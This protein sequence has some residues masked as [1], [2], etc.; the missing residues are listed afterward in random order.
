MGDVLSRI[1]K[2]LDDLTWI[3]GIDSV[4]LFKEVA[5]MRAQL[6]NLEKLHRRPRILVAERNPLRFLSVLLSALTEEVDLFLGNPGWGRSE[7]REA[8]RIASPDLLVTSGW[9]E[10]IVPVEWDEEQSPDVSGL[11]LMV[12]TGGSSG[13]VKFAMHSL[14]N[15]G[16]AVDG[17]C[18]HFSIKEIHSY[19]VLPLYHVSG[20]MQLFRA[21][22]T[23]GTVTLDSFENLEKGIFPAIRESSGFISLVPTQLNRLLI[24]DGGADWLRQFKAVFLGGGPAWPEL[25]KKG[26][27]AG[28]PLS[29]TYGM[30][31]SAA[32]VATLKP[33]AFLSGEND[34][35]R[36]LPHVEIFIEEEDPKT[37]VGSIW[38]K[39]DALFLGYHPELRKNRIL[40]QTDDL[41]FLNEKGSLTVVGRT[42]ELINSGGEKVYPGEVEKVIRRFLDVSAI[43]V[44]GIP[45]EIWG[46]IVCAV[47]QTDGGEDISE[48]K[49]RK[50]L[51][52]ELSSF[53]IPK[54]W[55]RYPQI[56]ENLPGKIDREAVRSWLNGNQEKT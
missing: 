40:W 19:C 13:K 10:G 22:L 30:T 4:A 47:Y 11:L 28:L 24:V 55:I 50:L 48:S 17:L 42:D 21:L 6:A 33:E 49:M 45:D 46:E 54:K 35:G 8:M 5:Q 23:N 31:E 1:E 44:L 36:A 43:V 7:Q 27:D 9:N 32:Q 37:E 34:A 16:V 12:P 29:L 3:K 56:L 25:L 41:G 39:S 26:R 38:L 2:G 51:K 52:D 53:K 15:L 14:E 18:Q 20:L